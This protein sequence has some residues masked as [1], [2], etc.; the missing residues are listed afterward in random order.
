[1][2]FDYLKANQNIEDKEFDLIYPKSF[3]KIAEFHFT[4]VAV[5]IKAAKYLAHSESTKIL[6]IGSGLGKFCMIGSVVTRSFF[7]GVEFRKR[8]FT[9]SN[10]IAK[11]YKLLQV[12][13]I[14]SN[15]TEIDFKAYDAFYLFN[16]FYENIDQ[17]T[18]INDE[19]KMKQHLYQT[20]S[21]Y[22]KNQL[23]EMPK[24][25]RV[26]TYFSYMKEIPDSYKVIKLDFDGKL[27][28]MKKIK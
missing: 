13:F 20:Y 19:I 10:K 22:V 7:T 27:K 6:D 4:P 11:K 16:S 18:A 15:V 1:M 26:V 25:T 23:E 28:M 8:L 24:G 9:A 3:R 17:S 2:V 21:A 12:E 14:Y 5:A